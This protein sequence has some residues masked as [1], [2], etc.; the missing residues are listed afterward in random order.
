M[1]PEDAIDAHERALPYC[2]PRH[3]RSGGDAASMFRA[4]IA[5]DPR[6]HLLALYLDTRHVPIG[7]HVVS[8]GTADSSAVHPREI[9]GPAVSLSAA[10]FVLCHNHPSGDPTPSAEDRA[11]TDRLKA[12]GTLLGVPLL[13]HVIVGTARYYSFAEEGFFAMPPLPAEGARS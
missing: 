10:A 12:A 2:R 4:I 8:I 11:V 13:D 1:L 3:L 9:L 6:E 7:T 5:D